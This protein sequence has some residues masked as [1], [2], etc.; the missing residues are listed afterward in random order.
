VGDAGP[1]LRRRALPQEVGGCCG[2]LGVGLSTRR[3][4]R[5]LNKVPAVSAK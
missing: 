5:Q 1:A 3:T 2:G 4:T